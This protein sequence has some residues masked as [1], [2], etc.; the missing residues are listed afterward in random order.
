MVGRA[1]DVHVLP[2]LKFAV[3][4]VCM[5]PATVLVLAGAQTSVSVSNGV[6]FAAFAAGAVLMCATASSVIGSLERV[7]RLTK[8]GRR[9]AANGSSRVAAA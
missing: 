5:V 7:A 8:R 4:T 2:L 9:A 6:A 1:S 3:G